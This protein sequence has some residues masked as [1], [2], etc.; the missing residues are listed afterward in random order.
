MGR[1]DGSR[2]NRERLTR[3]WPNRL[4][5]NFWRGEVELDESWHSHQLRRAVT[6]TPYLSGVAVTAPPFWMV[7]FGSSIVPVMCIVADA[8]KALLC[9][10]TG[11]RLVSDR[12]GWGGRSH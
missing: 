2:S 4:K 9:G 5:G 7:A 6:T 11:P 8:R 1:C 12:R 10:R 3:V